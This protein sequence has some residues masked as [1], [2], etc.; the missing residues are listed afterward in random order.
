M[1]TQQFTATIRGAGGGAFVDVPFDVER[2]YGRK[3]VPVVATIDGVEYR[4]SLVRMGG[5]AH[6]LL[7]R[8]DVRE[9][10]GKGI[11]DEVAITL[12]EDTAP[13]VVEVPEDVRAALGTNDVARAYFEGLSYTHQR[14][15]VGWIEEAKRDA[16]RRSRIEKMLTMLEQGKKAR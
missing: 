4:G 10:L 13:R 11:G 8:K 12:E 5:P 7:I 3:R 9:K 14:E 15:Y 6:M 16:T 1:P 2:V